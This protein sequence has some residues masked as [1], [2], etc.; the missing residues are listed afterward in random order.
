MSLYRASNLKSDDNTPHR[1]KRGVVLH[2]YALAAA[3]L[4]DA[5]GARHLFKSALREIKPDAPLSRAMALRD[6]GNFELRQGNV[7]LARRKIISAL[8]LFDRIDDVTQRVEIELAVTRG[9]LARTS[10][11]SDPIGSLET[12][13]DVARLLKGYKKREYE[14]DNLDWLIDHLPPSLERQRYALRAIQL[15]LLLGNNHKVVEYSSLF[16]GGKPLRGIYRTIFK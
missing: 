11:E 7:V 6:F 15:S 5:E 8:K 13:R 3:E 16:G 4:G 10:I 1:Y 2:V 9:F 14:L 12:L